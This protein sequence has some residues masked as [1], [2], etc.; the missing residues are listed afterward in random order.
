MCILVPR[1]IDT[2]VSVNDYLSPSFFCV[3]CYSETVC[4]IT[5]PI[6]VLGGEEDSKARP[7]RACSP[8]LRKAAIIVFPHNVDQRLTPFPPIPFPQQRSGPA[9]DPSTL[10]VSRRSPKPQVGRVQL[11]GS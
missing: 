5:R 6:V 10:R 9:E 2:P 1:L 4:S 3:L 8:N 11:S 7:Q